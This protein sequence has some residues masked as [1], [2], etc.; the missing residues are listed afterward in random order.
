VTVLKSGLDVRGEE[1]RANAN[2]MRALVADLRARE[3]AFDN[4]L[5]GVY[6]ADS[7]GA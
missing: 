4:R 3:I 5:P 1:F 6:R 7:G 2:A